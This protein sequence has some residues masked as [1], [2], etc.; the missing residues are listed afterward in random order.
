MY[1][2]LEKR[3]DEARATRI[4]KEEAE[5]PLKDRIRAI[6]DAPRFVKTDFWCNI[7]RKDCTGTGS[8]QVSTIRPHAPT[9]WYKGNCPLGHPMLRR[10]TDKAEDPYYSQ[11]MMIKRQ[12]AEAADDLL[13]PSDPRFHVLYPKFNGKQP[14]N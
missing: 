10:I 6:F 13:D 4:A 9:A 11:S 3:Y 2:N 12:R 8:R 7:C 14:T 5:R 1:E